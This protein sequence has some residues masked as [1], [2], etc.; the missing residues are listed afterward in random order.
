MCD[1][2][3]VHILIIF[4][5]VSDQTVYVSGGTLGRHATRAAGPAYPLHHTCNRQSNKKKVTIVDNEGKSG[6]GSK[7]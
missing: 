6:D 4:I 1:V 2:C 7:V 3:H 5:A